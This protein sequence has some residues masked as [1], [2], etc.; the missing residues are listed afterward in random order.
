MNESLVSK[1]FIYNLFIGIFNIYNFLYKFKICNGVFVIPS[2]YHYKLL[3]NY[4][5]F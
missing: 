1:Y 2:I 3:Y 4:L 5:S